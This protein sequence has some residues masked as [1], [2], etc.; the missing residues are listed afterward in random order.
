MPQYDDQHYGNIDTHSPKDYKCYFDNPVRM[1]RTVQTVQNVYVDRATKGKQT[2][3]ERIAEAPRTRLLPCTMGP[4]KVLSSA[5]ETINIKEDGI[6][7]EISIESVTI[8]IHEGESQNLGTRRLGF[9]KNVG[10]N[11]TLEGLV[12]GGVPLAMPW[13]GST[14]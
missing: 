9:Y 8:D 7:N 4:F 14:T 11:V 5:P 2:L 3:A 6:L 10:G 1:K 13:R 12:S